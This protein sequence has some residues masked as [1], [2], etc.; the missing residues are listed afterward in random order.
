[1][2]VLL[3]TGGD[4][5]AGLYLIIQSPIWWRAT[6]SLWSPEERCNILFATNSRTGGPERDLLSGRFSHAENKC[7]YLWSPS[8]LVV[9]GSVGVS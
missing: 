7:G 1:M 9:Y 6:V 4:I 3:G 8:M 2:D 5:E